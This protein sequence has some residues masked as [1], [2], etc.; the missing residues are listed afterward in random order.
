MI[1]GERETAPH[2]ALSSA[3]VVCPVVGIGASAGGL[4]ALTRLL[5]HLPATTGMAYVFVQHLDPTHAS[6]L[7]SLLAR[8]TTMPV[9]EIMNGMHAEANQVY[10]LPPNATLMLA[11]DTFILGPLLALSAERFAIDSFL[12]SLARERGPHAIGVLCQN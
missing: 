9:R 5:A 1:E 11:Q 6:L 8:V 12:R 3:Q 4:E 10:V 7:P 2:A